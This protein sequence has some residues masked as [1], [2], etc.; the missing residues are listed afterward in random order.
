MKKELKKQ[1]GVIRV[2]NPVGLLPRKTWNVLLVNAY[3][4]L[5]SKEE[6]T[7][8]I[9]TLS[10]TVGFNSKDVATLKKSLQKLQTTI[11]EWDVGGQSESKGV[12][13]KEFSSVQM[14]GGFKVKSGTITYRYDK[15][16]KE[17]LYNPIMYQKIG[18]AQ[19]KVFNTSYGLYLWENCLR[20]INVGSTGFSTTEEWRKL[21]GATV[22]SY[23]VYKDFKKH[24]LTPAINEINKLTNIFITLK[25][26]RTGRKI[27]HIGFDVE[28][29]KQELLPISDGLLDIKNS[30]E[31]K[32]LKSYKIADVQAITLIQGHGYKYISEKI[33]ILLE[34]KNIKNPSGFLI[35]AIEKDWKSS[36]L[37]QKRL[38]KKKNENNRKEEAKKLLIEKEKKIK[39]K[40]KKKEIENYIASLSKEK[41][42]EVDFDF[43]KKYKS[44]PMIKRFLSDGKIDFSSCSYVLRATYNTFVYD[45]YMK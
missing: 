30:A 35:E 22:K 18:I 28:E 27:T 13:F 25:T 31:Y 36:S 14:L 26:R 42:E 15:C 32:K 4:E 43:I 6:H 17:V 7:I 23:D 45:N 24:V 40:E 37:E 8:S 11:V 9:Q 34:Q 38:E 21:L 44:N 3:D 10:E 2:S 39:A 41:L 16:L 33:G 19:Q 29:N 12:S 5:L 1:V 20:Y